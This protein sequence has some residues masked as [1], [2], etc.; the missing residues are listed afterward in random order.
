MNFEK[1]ASPTEKLNICVVGSTYPRFQEDEQVPWLREYVN[2]MEEIG[3]NVTVYAPA[4]KG[5]TS[6]K[7]DGVT[8]ERFRYAPKVLETLTHDEGAT[9]KVRRSPKALLVIPYIFFGMIGAFRLAR[10]KNF[11]IIN[12]HWPF[13]HGFFGL[14]MQWINHA[15]IVSTCHGAELALG[16]K[17]PLVQLV[18]HWFLNCSQGVTCNS[19]HTKNEILKVCDRSVKVIPYG[20]S[21]RSIAQIDKKTDDPEA[22]PSLL[23]CGRLIERKGVDILLR[24][25]PRILEK[26]NVQLKITGEGDQKQ[27]WMRLT[28]ELGI[29]KHVHF[30][31]FVSNQ[32]LSVL[33]Q[34]CDIYVHPAIF[35]SRG[36]TEGLGVVLIEALLNSKPVV[37]SRVGGIIDVIKHNRTGLLVEEKDEE[38]LADAVLEL[39]EDTKF[40]ESLGKAGR[41]FALNYFDWDRIIRVNEAYFYKVRMNQIQSDL[42]PC[43]LGSQPVFPT[44]S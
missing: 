36:D 38:E 17:L 20:S 25:L 28:E 24:S 21:L 12:V 22:I 44:Q 41:D 18:L 26:K 7:I 10:K 2:R 11:D 14:A 27:K 34:M 3:H 13:P 40:A 31:G 39:L 30:L 6:H 9:N 37:A 35:D 1:Q 33:Y 16:R 4:Y 32:E 42:E 8:V 29:S 43:E 23:F 5:L 19:S 15:P